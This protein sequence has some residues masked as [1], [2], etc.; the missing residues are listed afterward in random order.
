MYFEQW[1]PRKL[2]IDQSVEAGLRTPIAD[3][4]PLVGKPS[5]AEIVRYFDA[6][7]F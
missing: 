4:L 1:Y 2:S 6:R 5:A 7:Y 3:H